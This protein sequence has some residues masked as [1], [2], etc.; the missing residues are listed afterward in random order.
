MLEVIYL[1]C[2]L[3]N[4][5]NVCVEWLSVLVVGCCV[6][7]VLDGCCDMCLFFCCDSIDVVLFKGLLCIDVFVVLWCNLLDMV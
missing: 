3:G 6:V 4:V 7:L 2:M 1:V 5:V